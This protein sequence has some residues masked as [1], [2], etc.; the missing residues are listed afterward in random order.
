MKWWNSSLKYINVKFQ[1]QLESCNLILNYFD[2]VDFLK[3]LLTY[4]CDDI[5]NFIIYDSSSESIWT[6]HVIKLRDRAIGL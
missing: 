2:K 6:T 1:R 5:R 4:L 3:I